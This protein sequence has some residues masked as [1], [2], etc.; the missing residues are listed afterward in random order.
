MNNSELHKKIGAMNQEELWSY[1]N[2]AK[3]ASRFVDLL[4]VGAI[5]LMIIFYSTLTLIIGTIA[6]YMMSQLGASMG[7]TIDFIEE[8]I[9]DLDK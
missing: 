6:V 4:G 8:R 5:F 7:R 9:V 3:G 2:A 1:L